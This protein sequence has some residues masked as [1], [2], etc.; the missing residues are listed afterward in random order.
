MD[1]NVS[2]LVGEDGSLLSQLGPQ[3][4][5]YNSLVPMTVVYIVIFC[6]GMVGN[7]ATCIVIA[8][9]Q[10][11]QSA[12]NYY[13]FNLAVADMLTLAFA[14]PMELFSYWQQYP[15]IFG[16][17]LCVLRYMLPEATT[18]ASI[19]TIV[20]FTTER[21]IAICHPMRTQTKSKFARAIRVI[22]FIWLLSFVAAIP[23]G[24][25]AKVNFVRNNR[26]ETIAESAW[27]G[28]P[29]NEPDMS[30]EALV[31][32]STVLFFVLPNILLFTLYLRIARTLQLSG[33]LRRCASAET[34]N[35]CRVE[36]TQIQSRQVVIRMLVAVV[37]A[38]F[39][40][41]LPFNMQRLLFFYVTLYSEWTPMLRQINQVLFYTA[42]VFFYI[43]C[44]INPILYNVMSKR[45][46]RA[47]R[48]KLCS[49]V[50]CCCRSPS[51]SSEL[52]CSTKVPQY[53]NYPANVYNRPFSAKRQP[54]EDAS[55]SKGNDPFNCS[56]CSQQ[57]EAE[58]PMHALK[59][60]ATGTKAASLPDSSWPLCC[61]HS[62]EDNLSPLKVKGRKKERYGKKQYRCRHDVNE[63]D[64]STRRSL[65]TLSQ[66]PN[67]RSEAYTKS[68]GDRPTN[69]GGDMDA[70]Y[71]THHV[72]V[73][74][75]KD[76][77]RLALVQIHGKRQL[78]QPVV[79]DSASA[80]PL[81]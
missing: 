40:C 6:T 78:D 80:Q 2:G 36:K 14:M 9:N 19:L 81:E 1:E 41:W 67:M 46:R 37:L 51:E 64:L 21:Y 5:P 58:L 76:S 12:T 75:V 32:A 16:H 59:T 56:A 20:S 54:A 34:G 13:L 4:L 55:S 31:I 72:L 66:T 30:W 7:C 8:K 71:R 35:S 33:L 61:T 60:G 68:D 73:A 63:R 74:G 23:W 29:F 65:L 17:V 38:F 69:A 50:R 49:R 3:H 11:M 70:T 47:F 53:R 62:D 27:C 43:N 42:G 22:G 48:D 26:N 25:Y 10:Y 79:I 77:S 28:P 52:R 15:W 57:K 18:Y 44:T 39:V 45:F 24:I